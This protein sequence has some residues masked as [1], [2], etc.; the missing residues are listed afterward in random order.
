MDGRFAKLLVSELPRISEGTVGLLGQGFVQQLLKSKAWH[1]VH[2]EDW[3]TTCCSQ[4]N[5]S[6][7]STYVDKQ[8]L[9]NQPL[10]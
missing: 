2:P 5:S 10:Y 3:V 4:C 8:G 7:T 6:A 9:R 1:P